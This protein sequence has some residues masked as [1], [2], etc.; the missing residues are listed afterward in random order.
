MWKFLTLYFRSEIKNFIIY[1]NIALQKS[2]FIL[3]VHKTCTSENSN[4]CYR[5]LVI[6]VD[7]TIIK[8]GPSIG[9]VT[10]KDIRIPVANLWLVSKRFKDFELKKVGNTIVFRSFKYNFDVSWDTLEDAKITVND[11]SF[12]NVY[13]CI[14]VIRISFCVHF[15]FTTHYKRNFELI[16]SV[17]IK[18]LFHINFNIMSKIAIRFLLKWNQYVTSDWCCA[19]IKMLYT[20]SKIVLILPLLNTKCQQNFSLFFIFWNC[21]VLFWHLVIF[22]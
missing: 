6:D 17:S 4:F 5:Y 18:Y 22:M 1:R 10:L 19:C 9:D 12:Y 11:K 21:K 16:Y 8:L 14:K 20:L 7:G 2:L 15:N 13:L 3:S